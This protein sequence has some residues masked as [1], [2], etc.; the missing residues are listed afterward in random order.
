MMSTQRDYYEVLGVEKSAGEADIKKAYRKL[1]MQ[2]H[3]DR[4]SEDK[5][6]E[7]EEKFKEIS[8]AYAVLSDSQK[9]QLY[10]QYGHAGIDSRFSTED[11]FRGADF[12]SIFRNMGGG[13]SIF[14]DLFSDMGFD[15][16]GASGGRRQRGGESIQ[17]QLEITLEEAA[18]GTEK[19]VTFPHYE[20]CGRCQGSGA[21]P[22]SSTKTCSY[23]RG[24][25]VVAT[26]FGFISMQQTCP[27]CHGQGK[28]IT[29]ACTQCRGQGRV[30]SQKSVKVKIPAGVDTGSVMRL[31]GEGNFAHGSRGDLYLHIAVKKHPLFER[32]GASIHCKV[33]VSYIRAILGGEIEVPTFDGKVK[34][35]IPAGTQPNTIFRLKG[36]G[37][38]DL[39]SK[40]PGDEFVQ[41]DVSIPTRLSGQEKKLLAELEKLAK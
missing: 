28:V 34:M 37:I 4:V 13:G 14:E 35:R 32:H 8:E 16:F 27:Q 20:P 11:I 22:G 1:V 6:K 26:G 21:E 24:R 18:Q 40:R 23:C 31:K 38:T 36:K 29:K 30:S 19:T 41:V 39:H 2:Y 5:K 12:S 15:I 7:A 25:G 3:P 10:D 9:R 33:P 17:Y